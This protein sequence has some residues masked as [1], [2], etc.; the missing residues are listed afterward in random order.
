MR[1]APFVMA[2]DMEQAGIASAGREE[3]K[4]NDV[5]ALIIIIINVSYRQGR[6]ARR[7]IKC[8]PNDGGS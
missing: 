3:E 8:K 1:C 6:R 7:S 4:Q 2:G 5:F